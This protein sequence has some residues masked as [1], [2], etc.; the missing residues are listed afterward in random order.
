MRGEGQGVAFTRWVRAILLNGASRYGEALETARQAIAAS[1]TETAITGWALPELIEAAVRTDD[2]SSA[3]DAVADLSNL[4]EFDGAG[5]W[6]LA[7]L[8][9]SRAL[10]TAG[11]RAERYFQEAVERFEH[12]ALKTELAR[13]HLL[14]G[15][16]LRRANRRSD[17]RKQLRSAHEF[18]TAMGAEAFAARTRR[19]L[20]ATGAKVRKHDAEPSSHLTA[21]EEHIARL[22]RD[23]RSNPEIAAALFLSTRTVEWHM[24]KVFIKLGITS[25]RGLLAALRD[26]DPVD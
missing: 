13:S 18:F 7:L 10:T 15:E 2:L 5:D 11:D 6:G 3:H 1:A 17:A 24:R 22:A 19:E 8:A 14:Y 12:T 20:V 9:R 16:W 21:Q 23:G 26:L 4:M 25:R